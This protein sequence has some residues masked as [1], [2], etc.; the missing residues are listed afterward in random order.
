[1][2]LDIVLVSLPA[3]THHTP[4]RGL[5]SLASYLKDK[6]YHFTCIDF[7]PEFYKKILPKF[8]VTSS[9]LKTLNLSPY[10]LWGA[11][12]WLGFE[13]I[14]KPELGHY[15]L[16]SLCPVCSKLYQPIFNEF[17]TQHS[18][19]LKI[20]N[21]YVEQLIAIDSRAYAFSLLLG[22]SIASLYVIKQI[23]EY[24]PDVKIIVGGPETSLFYRGA[25]YAHHNLI[26]YTV[27]HPEGEIPLSRIISHLRTELP[28]QS[29]PGILLKSNN[30]VYQT[31]PPPLL[32]LNHLPI[33]N[34]HLVETGFK[35]SQ[36]NSLDLLISKGCPY[37]CHFCNEALIWGP[38]RPK[39]RRSIVKEIRY[40]V[41]NYGITQFELADNTFSASPSLL[42]ALDKLYHSGIKISW[43]G[44][45]HPDSLTKSSI[46]KLNKYGLSHCYF[47]LESASPKIQNL[48]GKNLDLDYMSTILKICHQISIKSSLY[49]I[50]GF[51]GETATEFQ[52]SL[53]FI[54]QNR[55]YI[56]KV[57]VSVF[58][59]MPGT[60][61]F[62][63]NL[64]IPIQLGPKILNAFTYETKDGI[65]HDDRRHRF[66]QL[67]AIL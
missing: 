61:I 38:F 25:F 1:M 17:Q 8:K 56:N 66:F 10:P 34:F 27:Y 54:D 43:S 53:E 6:G 31:P 46:P 52:K 40:Y 20:L 57:L 7:G 9:L 16:E 67:H 44:N 33:P 11:S 64:L 18:F 65:S 42:P 3:F 35:S 37:H 47:G 2:E 62:N 36:L 63:S 50:V 4:S 58:N 12:N 45:C 49:F 28:Q 39:S 15:L 24:R 41:E 5:A 51:P 48:M 26:D 32:D 14:I 13:D 19:T 59:L 30:N 21:S 29:I 22:N 23:R 55:S 60:R